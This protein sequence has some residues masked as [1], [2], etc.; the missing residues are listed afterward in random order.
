M[1][2]MSDQMIIQQLSMSKKESDQ[3][4]GMFFM[5]GLI[6][7]YYNFICYEHKEFNADRPPATLTTGRRQLLYPAIKLCIYE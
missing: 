7:Q 1:A 5:Y 3:K 4:I 6:E 2:E